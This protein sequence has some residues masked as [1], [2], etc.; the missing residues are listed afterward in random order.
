LAFGKQ[1]ILHPIFERAPDFLRLDAAIGAGFQ[2]IQAIFS[3]MDPR[4]G[5][6]THFFMSQQAELAA[7]DGSE[8]AQ[9]H[10]DGQSPVHVIAH[11]TVA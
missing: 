8:N 3:R 7:L 2:E 6:I 4:G 10:V 5:V 11:G 1:H 9:A